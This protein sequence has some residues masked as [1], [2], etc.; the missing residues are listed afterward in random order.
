MTKT[1][2]ANRD[3]FVIV[4][5]FTAIVLLTL[6]YFFAFETIRRQKSLLNQVES[7]QE[8]NL[9]TSGNETITIKVDSDGLIVIEGMSNE[10]WLQ[11]YRSLF[12][13]EARIFE[14]GSYIMTDGHGGC[15]PRAA[16]ND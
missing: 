9:G 2:T 5:L 4:V 14:D 6:I 1:P 10:E 3:T 13:L 11:L 12:V 7:T 8:L 16:C 15:I